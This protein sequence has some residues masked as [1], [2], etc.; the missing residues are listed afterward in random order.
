MFVLF[1]AVFDPE[2][3]LYLISGKTLIWK[4]TM[5]DVNH[6]KSENLKETPQ[7]QLV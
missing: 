1:W 3:V 6:Q 7:L 4:I 2:L 5:Y